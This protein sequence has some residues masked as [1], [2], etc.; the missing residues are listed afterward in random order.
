M[1]APVAPSDTTPAHRAYLE[2]AAYLLREGGRWAAPNPGYD[3]TQA[4]SPSH[5][6]YQFTEGFAPA[7]LRLRITGRVGEKNYLYW[8]GFYFFHPARNHILYVSQGTGG[9]IAT[10]ETVDLTGAL[11]FDLV[12]PDGRVETHRDEEERIGPNEF[13]S[14][15]FTFAAGVWKPNQELHWRRAPVVAR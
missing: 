10:G 15:S 11:V 7:V 14:R 9:A 8:E 13:V 1:P 5:F 4:G 12:Q 2:R 6:G 3:S